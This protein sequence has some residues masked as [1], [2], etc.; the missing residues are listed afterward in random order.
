[1]KHQNNDIKQT[2][3]QTVNVHKLDEKLTRKGMMNDLKYLLDEQ[4]NTHEQQHHNTLKME[5]Q[6]LQ[7]ASKFDVFV[8]DIVEEKR[9]VLDKLRQERPF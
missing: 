8:D 2:F 7:D 5:K 1:V 9:K 4:S 3:D 6:L